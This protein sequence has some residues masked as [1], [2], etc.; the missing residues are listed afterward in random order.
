MSSSHPICELTN[1]STA[2]S[3]RKNFLM[4]HFYDYSYG[5]LIE[6]QIER[7]RRLQ[8]KVTIPEPPKDFV[9]L[10]K[11]EV[12]LL[13]YPSTAPALWRNLVLPLGYAK[14]MSESIRVD[15]RRIRLVP[16]KRTFSQPTWLGYDP[17]HGH[18]A[19][20]VQFIRDTCIA[21]IEVLTAA[22]QLPGLMET[23]LEGG[24][25]PILSACRISGNGS[26]SY[27]P[28]LHLSEAGGT[29][30]MKIIAADECSQSWAS[31]TV[32]MC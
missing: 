11:T 16:R 2:A 5:Q 24:S 26:W 32:R 6:H 23:W 10:T 30:E 25:M 14:Y 13:Y 1:Q 8:P 22:D 19:R 31:P 15:L 18:G 29:L 17:E 9:A 12:P 28:R 27:V 4:K 7:T 21:G 20:P 3:G